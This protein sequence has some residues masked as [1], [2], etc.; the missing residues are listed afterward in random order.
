MLFQ[1]VL[2]KDL[3]RDAEAGVWRQR[4]LGVQPLLVGHPVYISAFGAVGPVL[5]SGQMVR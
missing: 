4:A 2:L 3:G 1:A 5:A